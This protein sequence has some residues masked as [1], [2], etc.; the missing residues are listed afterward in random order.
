LSF[1][2]WYK[3]YDIEYRNLSHPSSVPKLIKALKDKDDEVQKEAFKL[4]KKI[5][6]KDSVPF[7]INALGSESISE[8]IKASQVL[9]ILNIDAIDSVPFLINTLQD[10]HFLVRGSASEALGKICSPESV[11]FLINSLSDKITHVKIKS[12]YALGNIAINKTLPL[13]IEN[14]IIEKLNETIKCKDKL[15]DKDIDSKGLIDCYHYDDDYCHECEDTVIASLNVIRKTKI[16]GLQRVEN[17]KS[18]ISFSQNI[19]KK[20]PVISITSKELTRGIKVVN[21]AIKMIKITG[22]VKDESGVSELILNDQNI[23]FEE[24]GAFSSDV[25]LSIGKNVIHIEAVDIFNNRALKSLIITRIPDKNTHE[26]KIDNFVESLNVKGNYYALIIGIN[27]YRFLE[28]LTT[29]VS[30]SKSTANILQTY[31]FEITLLNENV[32]RTIIMKELNKLR[33]KLYPDDKLLIYF[34][35]HGFFNQE[36]EKAYWLPVDAEK[37][38]T[39]N[40]IISD[41]VTSNLKAISANHILIVSDS[42]YSGTLTRKPKIKLSSNFS[43]SKYLNKMLK[44]KTR[45]LIS[46]G[47]NEPVVDND[48]TGH[49]VF[50]SALIKAL[51]KPEKNIFT[52]EELFVNDIKEAVVGKANQTPEYKYIINSGHDGGD[53]VFIKTKNTN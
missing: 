49:S 5:S 15:S 14:K 27:N 6:T 7:L 47:G 19:D 45:V 37:N 26:T 9:G 39:T 44:K 34:A 18:N 50:A 21:T 11:P 51:E 20:Q 30:D 25:L 41:S 22:F 3:N 12:I 29:A 48:G 53:F 28:K 13:S 38:D 1:S 36:T 32:T 52:A 33:Q 17:Y 31:G 8:R 16:K 24:S 35:G 43:R 46:S 40:W 4:L 2:A 23:K 10:E 42:C